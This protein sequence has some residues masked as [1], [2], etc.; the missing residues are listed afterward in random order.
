[1]EAEYIEATLRASE[2]NHKD[3]LTID[4]SLQPVSDDDIHRL[5]TSLKTN[6]VVDTL[7]LFG[8]RAS[9]PSWNVVLHA[10]PSQLTHLDLGDCN[11]GALSL[12]S[13]LASSLPT[14]KRLI[15]INLCKNDLCKDEQGIVPLF[16][17]LALLPTLEELSL[18]KNGLV[19][20][21]GITLARALRL[22]GSNGAN[23]S[24]T[25]NLSQVWL[26]SNHFS[27]EAKDEIKQLLELYELKQLAL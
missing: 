7:E 15:E 1:M 11:L 23:K 22:K 27:E 4:L 5:G 9:V 25:L 21:H 17:S 2:G 6:T 26:Q 24:G 10:L 20:S 19:D 13:P 12:L 16:N 14:L 8:I 18:Q 3:M